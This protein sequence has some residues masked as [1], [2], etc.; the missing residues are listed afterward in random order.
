MRIKPKPKN[1]HNR[2]PLLAEK[3]SQLKPSRN[4]QTLLL[5]SRLE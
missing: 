4:L 1:L 5:H 3:R 2:R